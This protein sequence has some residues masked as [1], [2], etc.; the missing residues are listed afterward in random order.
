MVCSAFLWVGRNSS[1]G[2]P[3]MIGGVVDGCLSVVCE[4]PNSKF[5]LWIWKEYGVE[6]T[7][8]YYC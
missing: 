6:E 2:N 3:S 4:Y 7:G 5:D 8:H 1:C